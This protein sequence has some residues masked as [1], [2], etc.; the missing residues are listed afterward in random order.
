MFNKQHSLLLAFSGGPDSVVL[1]H[2]LAQAGFRFSLAHCN[3]KLRGNDSEQDE[4]FSRRFAKQLGVPFYAQSFDVPKYAKA[5]GVST[6]MAAR[7]LRYQ[8]FEELR[9][10]HSHDWILT[11]HHLNDS[12]E[13]FFLNL[14]RGAGIHGL[15][16]IAETRAHIIRPMLEVTK[17]AILR[18]AAEH[19]LRYRQ[20]KS[21]LEADYDRNYLRLKILPLL[22]KLK[23]GFETVM[24][25]NLQ[26]V[27]KEVAMLDYFLNQRLANLTLPSKGYALTLSIPKLREEPFQE[28]VLQKGLA[29]FGFNHTQ[30]KNIVEALQSK[31][32]SG[33][34]VLSRS[35]RLVIDRDVLV[36]RNLEPVKPINVLIQSIEE[37]L[38]SPHLK[39]RTYTGKSFKSQST[40]FVSRNKLLFPLEWRTWKQGDTFKPYGMKGVKKLSDL[41][42]D[43]KLNTFEKEQC[44]VL[45]NG[46][47]ELMWVAGYRSDDRYKV[48]IGTKQILSI[49]TRD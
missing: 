41:F 32:S 39:V 5:H 34:Q 8:W 17:S 9:T 31:T 33:K 46:N 24:S 11:A 37:L 14:M 7:D 36:V 44:R 1:A 10:K 27:Q 13:T 15:T 12:I 38:A 19:R 4:A 35:H 29:N 6:Q 42:K 49:Q 40:F 22:Q 23:P 2:L 47:G 48:S 3:F 21:N 25:S 30:F 18:Y 28:A 16:G 20:D 45:V 26:H 43:L